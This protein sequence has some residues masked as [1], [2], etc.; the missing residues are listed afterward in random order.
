[1]LSLRSLMIFQTVVDTGSFTRAAQQLY[2]TQSAV[3][4]A[5]REL[6]ESTGMVLFDRVSRRVQLTASGILLLQESA[7]LL[8]ASA[9]LERRLQ[10]PGCRP[11]IRLVSS[12]TISCFWL[13]KILA[14]WKAD[15]PDVRVSVQVVSAREA[16]EVLKRG[17]AD[18][19]LIEGSR[20]QPP[21]V[22]R[23]FARY[24]LKL[25]CAPDYRGRG[26]GPLVLTLPEFCRET[27]LL[28]EPGSAIRDTL[29]SQL[30]LMGYQVCPAWQSVNSTALLEAA[31]AGLGI[32][33]L[34]D[35]LVE[36]ELEAGRLREVQAE[37]LELNNGLFAV[38]HK[39][40]YQ[41]EELKQLLEW[42]C[43]GEMEAS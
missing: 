6:E 19:A 17:E 15:M 21:F 24:Q 29:D 34:P 40:K 39:E 35:K 28:R 16:M 2:I 26:D 3:S 23:R 5:I 4:H 38:W 12:I 9:R 1:M 7:E 42:V 25:V 32:A 11:P 31:R 41:T 20:P 10:D 13:P 18:L 30:L 33:V 43:G 36:T 14:K 22:C 27:L 37:S 8:E